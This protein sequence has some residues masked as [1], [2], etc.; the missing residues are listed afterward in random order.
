MVIILLGAEAVK[1]WLT[2]NVLE[3]CSGILWIYIYVHTSNCFHTMLPEK[4]FSP[5]FSVGSEKHPHRKRWRG[6]SFFRGNCFWGRG[7][8]LPTPQRSLQDDWTGKKMDNEEEASLLPSPGSSCGSQGEGACVC[9]NY[10]LLI[11]AQNS[12]GL[13]SWSL[14]YKNKRACVEPLQ[15]VRTRSEREGRTKDYPHGWYSQNGHGF[16]LV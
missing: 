8:S 3:N 6:R 14:L 7:R 1:K 13:H 2:V 9:V 11:S 15:I 4:L 10:S 12:F 5:E 16:T